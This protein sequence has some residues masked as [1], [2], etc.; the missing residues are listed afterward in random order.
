MIVNKNKSMKVIL[1]SILFFM[2]VISPC[3]YGAGIGI[4]VWYAQW[5][6]A[7]EDEM[8]NPDLDG[9]TENYFDMNPS[10]MYGPTLSFDIMNQWKISTTA[11]FGN[12]DYECGYTMSTG[13]KRVFQGEE[14]KWDSDVTLQYI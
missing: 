9:V 1:L 11:L 13:K 5:K 7:W 3:V 4:T 10:F 6:P 8:K 12:F 14:F 2:F